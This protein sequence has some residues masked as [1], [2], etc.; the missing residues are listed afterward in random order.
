MPTQ[1]YAVYSVF[2]TF[3]LSAVDLQ[4][5]DNSQ[6]YSFVTCKTPAHKHAQNKTQKGARKRTLKKKKWGQNIK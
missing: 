2:S 3:F 4:E 5:Q 6:F 1:Q